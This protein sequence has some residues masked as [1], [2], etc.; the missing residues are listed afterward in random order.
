MIRNRLAKLEQTARKSIADCP[1]CA[2][3]PA[4][5]WLPGEKE[6]TNETVRCPRCGKEQRPYMIR[7]VVP[8]LSTALLPKD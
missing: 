4:Q 3:I 2:R 5:I 1:A 7:I 8:R 6:P